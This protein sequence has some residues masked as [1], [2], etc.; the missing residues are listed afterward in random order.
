M[1]LLLVKHGSWFVFST[2]LTKSRVLLSCSGPVNKILLVVFQL[3][4]PITHAH[5][6]TGVIER[7]QCSIVWFLFLCSFYLRVFLGTTYVFFALIEA[8]R[9]D[10][11]TMMLCVLKTA[12]TALARLIWSCVTASVS[13][14]SFSAVKNA[15]CHRCD[16]PVKTHRFPKEKSICCVQLLISHQTESASFRSASQGIRS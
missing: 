9:D 15:V 11:I 1:C 16:W 14:K 3:W 13:S 2:V 7:S 6:H 4:S 10:E 8:L 5:N 12:L